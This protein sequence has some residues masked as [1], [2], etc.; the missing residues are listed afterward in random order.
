SLLKVIEYL[1]DIIFGYFQQLSLSDLLGKSQLLRSVI[2][3]FVFGTGYIITTNLI[4]I[5]L[6]LTISL[7]L[8][9]LL[10]DVKKSKLDINLLRSILQNKELEVKTIALSNTTLGITLLVDSLTV[11][12]P[13]YLLEYNTDIIIV[14][15]FSSIYYII[16]AAS[17]V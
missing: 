5:L 16:V 2:F 4:F 17:L 11:N 7:L 12:V 3:I 14:G 6:L 10:Y 1:S 15:Y 8:R 9:L 13:R